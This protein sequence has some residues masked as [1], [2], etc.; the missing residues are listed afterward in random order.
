MVDVPFVDNLLDRKD[1]TEWREVPVYRVLKQI[2]E[3]IINQSFE[4]HQEGLEHVPD[5][6]GAILASNHASWFD[7]VFI[8][9]AIDRPVHWMAKASLFRNPLMATFFRKAGQVKVDRVSGGNQQAVDKCVELSTSGRLVGIF[10]EGSRSIDGSLRRGRTGVARVA[11]RSG[12]PLIPLALTSY[13][14]LP[15]HATVPNLDTPLVV[16]AGEP[17]QYEGMSDRVDDST[18]TRK[19]TDEIM[20]AIGRELEKARTQRDRLDLQDSGKVTQF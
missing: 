6:G 13:S 18:L 8:G 19:I 1:S 20:D 9:E 10:A 11:L 16:R 15:K 2:G 3:P 4:L 12:Q 14:V 7:P 17:I 5:E